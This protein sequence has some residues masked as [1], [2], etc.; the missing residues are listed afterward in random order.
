MK[1][2]GISLSR[3]AVHA[4][5]V[6]GGRVVWH[7][8]IRGSESAIV[9]LERLLAEV[10]S[11]RLGRTSVRI[12]LGVGHSYVKRIEGLPPVRQA[13]LLNRVVREN[14]DSFFLRL[15]ARTL[16][17]DVDRRADGSTWAA[18][19]DGTLIDEALA[20]L[21]RRGLSVACVLP[22]AI[23]SARE[24]DRPALKALGPEA[25]EFIAA[26]GAAL[27]SGLA[28]LTWRPPP[29]RSHTRALGIARVASSSSLL[30]LALCA[31]LFARG[32]HAQRIAATAASE[33]A[34]LQGA[35]T[36]AARVDAELRRTAADLDRFRQLESTRG[37]VTALLGALSEALPD[38][39]AL[40]SLRVDS[41]D[42]TFVALTPHAADV[43]PPLFGVRGLVAP[44]IVGSVT[45]EVQGTA[46]V[47]RA[48]IRFRRGK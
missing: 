21:R 8:T 7:S 23:A 27:S 37:R 17:S 30:V 36:D 13:N 25:H 32:V 34:A 22:Y 19:F 10:P 40:V 44:R 43:L 18:A 14:A 15:G 39:T 42:A 5:L 24:I 31:A 9:A 38:S 26:Y 2:L 11:A 47:E 4:V 20:V 29:D 28:P 48:T 33:L 3:D 45:R 16:V 12:S 46:H 35:E 6:R 41:L 1:R